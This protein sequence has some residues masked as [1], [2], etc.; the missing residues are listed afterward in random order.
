[1]TLRELYTRALQR[2]KNLSDTR[3]TIGMFR[4]W[5]NRQVQAGLLE[6]HA[7]RYYLTDQ[8]YEIA[9]ELDRMV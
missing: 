2:H 3:F 1:M 8:G 4:T 5:L 7:G 9:S 6:Q